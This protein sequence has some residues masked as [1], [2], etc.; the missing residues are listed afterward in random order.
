MSTTVIGWISMRRQPLARPEQLLPGSVTTR[1]SR[2]STSAVKRAMQSAS[3]HHHTLRPVRPSA[4]TT[5]AS[6][7]SMKRRTERETVPIISRLKLE[8]GLSMARCIRLRGFLRIRSAS[9]FLR[10]ASWR[11]AMRVTAISWPPEA[12]A[13]SFLGSGGAT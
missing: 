8:L 6:V 10:A 5:L 2:A 13:S 12:F 1:P 11:M 4:Q 9:I 7:S 3:I